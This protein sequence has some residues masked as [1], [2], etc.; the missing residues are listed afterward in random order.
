MRQY[1]I[2]QTGENKFIPQTTNNVF[3]LLFGEWNG[4]EHCIK[5]NTEEWYGEFAQ[6][7]YCTVETMEEAKRIIEIHKSQQIYPKYHKVD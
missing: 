4:I 5:N 7:I 1:R 6:Q 3:A 2:K